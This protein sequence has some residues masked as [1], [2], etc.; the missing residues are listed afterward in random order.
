MSLH[1]TESSGPVDVREFDGLSGDEL[2]TELERIERETAA[3]AARSV[4]VME[5]MARARRREY[6]ESVPPD[7]P[8]RRQSLDLAELDACVVDE[9]A[10][11]TGLRRH[12][13]RARLTLGTGDATRTRPVLGALARGHLS[14]DRARRLMEQS[15]EVPAEHVADLVERV[16]APYPARSADGVGGLAVPHDVFTSRLRRCVARHVDARARHAERLRQRCTRIDVHPDGE[17]ELSIT[18]HVL[19]VAAAHERVDHIARRL[20]GEG[21]SRTLAQLRSDI[22]LD[23]LLRGELV[24]DDTLER[25]PLACYSTFG[26]TL[27]PARVDVVISAASLLGASEDPG[28][29]PIAGRHEWITAAILRDAAFAAGSTWRRLVT[30]PLTGHLVDLSTTSYAVTGRLR[31]RIVARDRVSRVPGSTRPAGA[32]DMD[33]DIDHAD[34]GITGE[35]NVSAKDR[36]GHNHKTRRTW[37][38]HREVDGDGRII[39]TTPTGRRYT[40]TP[41]DYR[42]PD[43]PSPDEMLDALSDPLTTC[44]SGDDRSA[45]S[46][47][48]TAATAAESPASATGGDGTAWTPGPPTTLIARCPDCRRASTVD[49]RLPWD[50]EDNPIIV[51]MPR[52]T[53][54]RS[55]SSPGAFG[56][57][58]DGSTWSA[59]GPPPF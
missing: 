11:A 52:S 31:E 38:A 2:L 6:L 8:V 51:H 4:V 5:V 39:W 49:H 33:H 30:D 10:L 59:A 20:R 55:T 45:A 28:M 58:D 48:D 19:R 34:G 27:P 41:W 7:A 26:G 42:D 40:T 14:W 12:E 50:A 29:V 44:G 21:D 15:T 13:C 3:L 57:N 46:V 47:T 24:A 56:M 53:R 43:P 18:G 54:R 9:V 36:R 25:D 17:A 32:C 1:D 23:L 35:T 37:R 22:A 16:V